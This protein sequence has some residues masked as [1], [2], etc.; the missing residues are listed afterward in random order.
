MNKSDASQRGVLT[1]IGQQKVN[2]HAATGT[3]LIISHFVFGDGNGQSVT[4]NKAGTSLT[5]EI[6]KEPITESTPGI[7]S[8]GIFMSSK[9]AAKYKGQWIREAGLV[10]SDGNL[11][12]WC[13]Y[14]PTLIALFTERQMMI[15][16]PI[17][18]SDTVSIAI[19]TSKKFVSLDEFNAFKNEMVQL[20][21]TQ[22]YSQHAAQLANTNDVMYATLPRSV[23][24]VIPVGK[25][26]P[27]NDGD[28][29]P[30][31]TPRV[32]IGYVLSIQ[33]YFIDV[34]FEQTLTIIEQSDS[35]QD[36]NMT[37]KR[38]G[39][40]F[41]DAQQWDLMLGVSPNSDFAVRSIFFSGDVRAVNM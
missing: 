29:Y 4:P 5:H 19:D 25:M 37:F 32:D 3:K 15:N 31:F 16:I 23:M 36:I 35:K 9:M 8:G 39:R 40:N 30:L 13:S 2:A 1:D 26:Q 11:I 12:I 20:A 6:G 22:D 28:N 38:S 7:L 18:S 21:R 34:G 27:I 17:L 41:A 14:S 33:T 24:A 10:D